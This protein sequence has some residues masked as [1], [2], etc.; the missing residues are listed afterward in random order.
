MDSVTYE[1]L[2]MF[3][4]VL[5]EWGLN[6]WNIPIGPQVKVRPHLIGLHGSNGGLKR[7]EVEKGSRSFL[8]QQSL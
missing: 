1:I 7:S 2:L 6:G 5:S 4:K 8:K 3:W